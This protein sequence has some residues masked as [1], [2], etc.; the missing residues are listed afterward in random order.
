MEV[1]FMAENTE[2]HCFDMKQ[3]I[4]HLLGIATAYLKGKI[5]DKKIK[6]QNI[7]FI[8]L[9]FGF[10]VIY[11]DILLCFYLQMYHYK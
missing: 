5:D 2:I 11:L 3:M 4:C 8:Y 1:I 6:S 9:L 7:E 10:V